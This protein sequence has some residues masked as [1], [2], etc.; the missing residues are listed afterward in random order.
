MKIYIFSSF[1]ILALLIVPSVASGTPADAQLIWKV[2]LPDSGDPAIEFP[3]VTA[4]GSPV[5]VTVNYQHQPSL[6]VFN[7]NGSLLWNIT[8]A[9]EK[10]PWL[11][12]VSIVPDGSWLTVT[13]L[14]PGCCH[15]SVTNTSQ[16]KVLSF[17]RTGKKS[18]EFITRSPPLSL[19]ILKTTRD[20]LV[21]TADGWILCLNENG[22]VRWKTTVDV[23]VT[24][25]TTSEDG[26]TIIATGD[27]NYD[28]GVRYGETSPSFDLFILN[29]NGV[30]LGKYLTKEENIAKTSNNG[31]VIAVLSRPSGNLIFFNRTG[32]K[33]NEQTFPVP[34][35][36]HAMTPDGSRVIIETDRGEVYCLDT[37]GLFIWNKSIKPGSQGLAVSGNGQNFAIGNGS[38]FEIYRITGEPLGVYPASS[39]IRS[40]TMVPGSDSFLAY[41]DRELFFIS[42]TRADPYGEHSPVPGSQIL[43]TTVQVAAAASTTQHSSLSI[44]FPLSAIFIA[45]VLGVIFRKS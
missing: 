40:I 33:L 17:D 38:T 8:L 4:T 6:F 23:P 1:F 21:G 11:S 35:A 15:G 44:I 29:N 37:N 41:S 7:G 10:T 36:A 2:P 9:A 45:G 31:S 5:L 43:P 34:P 19:S 13:Q 20:I 3:I 24:T 14:V 28:S 12:S 25:L 26:S 22:S 30:I 18:W 42:V 27:S 39:K 32:A 16:N